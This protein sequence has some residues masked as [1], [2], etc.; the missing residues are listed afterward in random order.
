[1]SKE[2]FSGALAKLRQARISYIISVLP[3]A[4]SNSIPT[5]TIFREILFSGLFFFVKY[6]QE[7]S[8]SYRSS[9]TIKTLHY[10]TDVQIYNS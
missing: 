7:S 5:G 2:S 10:T 8:C 6:V 1:M 9:M 4:W 3:S